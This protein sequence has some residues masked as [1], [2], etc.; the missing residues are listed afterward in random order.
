MSTY[1]ITIQMDAQTVNEL[2]SN[3]FNLYGLQAVKGALNGVPTVWFQTGNYS[4][5]TMITW[6]DQYEAY[7]S[8]S[9]IIPQGQ[10]VANSAY[11]ISPG[12]TLEVTSSSGTGNVTTAGT[13]GA[14]AILNQT[15]TQ[16]TCGISAE[17][18][19]SG[20]APVCA[21]PLF[22][23]NMDVIAPAQQVFLMFSNFLG[24]AGTVIERSFSEGILI[25]LSSNASP[26]VSFDI[27]MGWSAAGGGSTTYPPNT[28]LVPLL[29]QQEGGPAAL[30]QLSA[31]SQKTESR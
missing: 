2:L 27:N 18:P 22:G 13:A 25:D 12:Q 15:S 4:L 10:I 21:F 19:G 31:H 29:I 17:L 6:S 7:T 9:Q 5:E 8:F 30:G 1:S 24:N 26:T 3:G 20:F 16:F 23:F 14:I 28:N 11:A